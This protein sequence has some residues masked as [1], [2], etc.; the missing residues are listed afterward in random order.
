MEKTA[1]EILANRPIG[2]GRV[3]PGHGMVNR[4]DVF[5]LFLDQVLVEWPG[6]ARKSA[7]PTVLFGAYFTEKLTKSL[8]A[9][10]RGQ[11]MV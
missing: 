11:C 4:E 8:L 7:N 5:V 2:G 9:F 10:A 1:W 3:T 6:N